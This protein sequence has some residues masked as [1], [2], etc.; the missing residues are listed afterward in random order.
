MTDNGATFERFVEEVRRRGHGPTSE[1]L[2]IWRTIVNDPISFWTLRTLAGDVVD[3]MSRLLAEEKD[4]VVTVARAI[5]EF[6]RHGWAASFRMPIPAVKEALRA[7][8][9]GAPWTV[10]EQVLH[11]GWSKSG[12]LDR[13]SVQVGAMGAAD[14]E[15]WAVS[16]Q[17]ARLIQAA[18]SH[19]TSGAF[20][21]SI[22][23]V[24][25]QVDGIVSDATT[26]DK[27][28]KGKR[29]FSSGRDRADVV[30]D[31][32][33]AGFSEALPVV[34]DW[35]SEAYLHTDE[36]GSANRHGVMHGRE[37][38]YD[39][40]VNST[41]CFV[42]LLAVWEWANRVFQIEA[43]RRKTIRYQSHAGS[44]DVDERGWRLDRRGFTET[45]LALRNL[46]LAQRSYRDR[47]DRYGTLED[48]RSDVVAS[49]LYEEK[50]P[51]V[52]SS[53]DHWSAWSRSESGWVFAI[54][55]SPDSGPWYYDDRAP[56]SAQPP[57]PGW[58]LNDDGNWS[59]D[60]YW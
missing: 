24:L 55:T 57:G 42:L 51:E 7:Y 19:H 47:N 25:A 10:V 52:A 12:S 22:P 11:D 15:L 34:R 59:G 4:L 39:T 9:S 35:F 41:K 28:H 8:D 50:S 30:D 29:F 18:W 53:D 2:S 23:I 17:R 37:L 32:T 49:L 16:K 20:E 46:D 45:R 44:D 36:Q 6:A 40:A 13:L 21:A 48:L 5:K 26:S 56:P 54:A 3:E 1:D 33:L 14:D 60:C 43:D 27:T 38:A 58:R 31:E